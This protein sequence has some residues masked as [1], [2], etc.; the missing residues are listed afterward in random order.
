M[1]PDLSSEDLR[2]VAAAIGGAGRQ[3]TGELEATL[4]TSGRSNL[5]YAITDGAS[6]WILRTPPRVGRTPS[7]HDVA[8]ELRVT[9]A[10]AATDVPVAAPV[11]LVEDETAI[12]IP[13]T[14]VDFV[15]GTAVQTQAQLDGF[16]DR[17][18]GD[19]VTSLVSTLATLHRVSPV[20]VG[21]E[22]FGRPDG[23]AERQLR[24]WSRQWETVGAGELGPLAAEV[25]SRLEA[26]VPE[27]RATSVVH[28]DYRIDNT[29]LARDGAGDWRVAAVVDWELSTLG[30]PVADVAMMCAYRHPTF[31]LIVGGPSAWTSD[32]LPSAASLAGAYEGA[33][34]VPLADWD[35]HLAL[36]Y[37]KVAVIAAGIDHRARAGAASGAG[38]S[39]AGQTVEPY[40]CLALA[41]VG[42]S[43]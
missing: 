14:V 16:D 35:F 41:T 5:T 20:A 8:R 21:L 11:V 19:V 26:A 29:I 42:A 39:T 31:D 23:Y 27:Q 17:E 25:A 22:G 32:R 3:V 10:L 2:V 7:A 33:G 12:G 15:D 30:D 4:I 36:A 34:G 6:R 13:F 43:A 28:G 40:L 18:L 9:A 1:S 38:F 37:Y 24:R